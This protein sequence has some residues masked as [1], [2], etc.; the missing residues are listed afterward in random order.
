MKKNIILSILAISF[1]TAIYSQ[2]NIQVDISAEAGF[3]G[4]L[5]HVIQSGSSTDKGDTFNYVKQGNQDTLIPFTRFQ[6]DLSLFKRHHLIF[7]YQPLTIETR[8]P[9]AGN[10]RYDSIDYT[11]SDGFLDLTYAFDFWRFS[12]LFDI[13]EPGGFFLSAGI[14]LQIRNASIIFKA[15]DSLKGSVTDNIGP[16]PIIKL[17]LGYEWGNGLFVLFDG[18]GFYASNKFLNGADYPFMGYIYDLS[19]RGGYEFNDSTSLFLNLRF[20]GGG[21]EG[22][23]DIDQY[24]YNDLHTFGLTLGYV[25]HL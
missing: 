24:T 1:V 3:T 17:R 12:Y 21:A 11:P 6:A 10:F 18:D 2:S 19:L 4:I 8:A 14:S 15:S 20:L 16:V 9:I 13:I 5:T 23:N 22:T 25:L 7:L